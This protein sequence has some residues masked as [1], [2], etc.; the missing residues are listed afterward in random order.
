MIKFF[1]VLYEDVGKV[2]VKILSV[3]IV[4]IGVITSPIWFVPYGIYLRHK[5][6]R[7]DT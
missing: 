2:L 1:D 5:N 7:S 3:T 6:G 4:V